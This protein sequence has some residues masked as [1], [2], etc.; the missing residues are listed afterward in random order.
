MDGWAI[1]CLVQRMMD[2]KRGGKMDKR[3]GWED[4]MG[5]AG[6]RCRCIFRIA[7]YIYG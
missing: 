1:H 5:G 2:G 3:I 6:Y 7:C 4:R